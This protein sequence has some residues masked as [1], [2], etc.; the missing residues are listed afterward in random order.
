MR[1]DWAATRRRRWSTSRIAAA[2]ALHVLMLATLML[3]IDRVQMPRRGADRST[4]L[5]AFVLRPAPPPQPHALP[6]PRLA[7]PQPP[8]SL[9]RAPE[10]RAQPA[11]PQAITLPAPGAPAIAAAAPPA[12]APDLRF[13]DGAATRL[14]IRAAAH[15]QTL[16]SQGNAITGTERTSSERLA[17]GVEAAHKADCMK[18]GGSMGLLAAPVILIAEAMGKCA[19]KL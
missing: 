19:H 6:L 16:A 4:T 14:A 9:P 8:L 3:A 2:I 17:S 18:A 11:Q 15:G 5:L 13:L 1:D 10:A 7:R 12:S